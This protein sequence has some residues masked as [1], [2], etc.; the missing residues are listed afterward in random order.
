VPV[1]LGSGAPCTIREIAATIAAAMPAPPRIVW[2]PSK[3]SGDPVRLL[4][5]E[6]AQRLLGFAPATSLA[7]GVAATV[8]WYRAHRTVA[9][10]RTSGLAPHAAPAAV[11]VE[12]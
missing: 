6:R 8:A 4:S 7:A 10:A 9:A 3:P 2:D 5:I 12:G 11:E 1:N